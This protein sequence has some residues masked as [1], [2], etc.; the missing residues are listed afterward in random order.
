MT[1]KNATEQPLIL[2]IDQGTSSSRAI[3]FDARGTKITTAQEAFPQIYP[4]S[5]EVEHNPEDIWQSTL[6]VCRKVMQDTALK[7]R[8]VGI[9]ITNQRETTV[10]WHKKTGQPLGNAIV[11]Q[12]RRTSRY[13]QQLRSDGLEPTIQ[14]KT[15][16]RLDP[17]FS[18]S[19]LHWLLNNIEG[20]KSKADNGELCFGTVDS[21]LL[22]RLT[23]GKIHATD[24]T[25]ASRTGLYNIHEGCWDNDLLK[26]YDIP[27]SLL[28]EV[29]DSSYHF[30]NCDKGLLGT[31]LPILGIAGDQQAA[32]FGQ[33][34]FQP[35]DSKCTLG[36]GAFILTNTGFNATLSENRLLTTIAYQLNGK[37]TYA[38]EGSIF[39][40]GAGV[41]WLRDE[42]GII[43]EAAETE[44]L[45]KSLSNNGGVYLV[46]AFTGLGAPYWQADVRGALLGLT[47]GTGR[48]HIAR[49]TLEAVGYQI[50]D[51]LQA[52]EADGAKPQRL[53]MDGGMLGNQWLIQFI[54]DI[55]NLPIDCPSVTETTALG[56]AYLAGLQ[57]GLYDGLNTIS[58]YWKEAQHFEPSMP[59]NTRETALSG[60]KAAVACLMTSAE[61]TSVTL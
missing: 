20:A 48:A 11:W 37:P 46:P 6:N 26:L 23:G 1:N 15:G 8:V 25:N 53:R 21:F 7:D 24:A 17:Y 54:S 47:R 34:C 38:L 45:A 2:A 32:T 55:L 9:G 43:K 44:A 31:A 36:T 14:A 40:A 19:K 33:A 39:I 16:L 27:A 28:P 50:A 5:G 49:A 57:A 61:N 51:L 56:A 4:A 60:W 30:G 41:Q 59:V 13:C 52:M 42:L 18:A 10:L 35:G 58:D 29:H 22:Y 3:I 12:D